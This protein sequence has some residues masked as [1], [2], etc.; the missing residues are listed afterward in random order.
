[1]FFPDNIEHSLSGW[2]SCFRGQ[3]R[4]FKIKEDYIQ[5]IQHQGL[6]IQCVKQQEAQ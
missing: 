1:M 5:K 4:M 2:F 3:V 6:V